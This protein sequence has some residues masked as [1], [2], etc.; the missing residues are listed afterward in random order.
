MLQSNRN[1]HVLFC[2]NAPPNPAE[3]D[4]VFSHVGKAGA[5]SGQEPAQPVRSITV[6]PVKCM[7]A[8][9]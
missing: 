5:T 8:E 9:L 1:N 4:P 6:L 3:A 7:T 2:P